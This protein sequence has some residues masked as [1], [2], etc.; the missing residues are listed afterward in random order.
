MVCGRLVPGRP[1]IALRLVA[2]GCKNVHTQRKSPCTMSAR[3]SQLKTASLELTDVRAVVARTALLLLV[4]AGLLILP[5]LAHDPGLR[6]VVPWFV[7][8]L[9]LQLAPLMWA[10]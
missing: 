7:V 2:D 1:C 9:M 4:A 5:G 6:A 10:R 3:G 8:L